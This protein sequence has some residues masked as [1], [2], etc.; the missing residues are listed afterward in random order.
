MPNSTDT[1]TTAT[2]TADK[3][4]VFLERAKEFANNT[5]ELPNDSFKKT[6]VVA[7]ALCLVG[8]I[9][10]SGSA[11]ALKPLQQVNKS[12]D[13]RVNILDVAG[14]LE[15]G[16]DVD[17]A[18]GDIET[19]IIDLATGD[20]DET[21]DPKTFDQWKAAKDPVLGEAIPP[22]KDKANIK[23]RP[24]YAKVYLVKQDGRVKSVILPVNGYGLWST[25]YGFIALESDGQTV[26]GLNL[27]DQAETPGLGGE[28]V[29]P[30]WKAL[31][32][33]KKVY[34]FGGKAM[35][36]SN[37]SEKGQSIEIGEVALGLV[38]GSVDPTKPGAEYQVDALAGATL[39]SRGV[40]NL[41]QYWMGQEGYGIYLAKF[42]S[43]RG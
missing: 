16:I 25:M 34:N 29:N 15:P 5:L 18:F 20:Y 32:H 28:V 33:G 30:K 40:S 38:K 26:V 4:A 24:K 6:L 27:Y 1:N 22:D 11:V 21:I 9:L 2:Q 19:K 43:R 31:W 41:V 7:L 39:T 37:L 3:F 12:K 36:E 17:K 14:L 13:E 10:V 42:R 35:H 23:R 8:A